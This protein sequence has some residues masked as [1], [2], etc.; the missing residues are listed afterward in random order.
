MEKALAIGHRGRGAGIRQSPAILA[1]ILLAQQYGRD[2]F[3][4]NQVTAGDGT[5]PL[6]PLATVAAATA[7][8]RSGDRVHIAPGHT[9]NITG[10]TMF[11][12]NKA[13]VTYIG[14]GQGTTRPRFTFTATDALLNISAANVVLSNVELTCSIDEVVTLV[15]VT[16]AGVV[17]DAVDYVETPTFQAI[18]FLLTTN[19]ADRIEVCNCRHYNT[20]AAAGTG[21]WIQLVGVDDCDIHDNVFHLTLANAAGAVTISGSTALVR[22]RIAR[23]TITQLGGTTQVSAI[24]LVDSSTTHVHDNRVACGSTALAGGVDV[25][26]AGYANEN[27]CLNTPDKSGIID[28][29]ADS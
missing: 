15:K 13:G 29:V 4:N 6:A 12:L 11:D 25:G 20:T 3:V 7:L 21:K 22:G 19:A 28:P 17:L 8:A 24:L 18:Q 5:D 26:N 10:A 9:E 27:Y 23:N 14:Y 1:A 2:I 16:A